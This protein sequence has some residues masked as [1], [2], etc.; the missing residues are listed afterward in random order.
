MIGQHFNHKHTITNKIYKE[1]NLKLNT[2]YNPIFIM[3]KT[4]T[5]TQ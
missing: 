5:G 4:Q 3:S 2:H 1:T